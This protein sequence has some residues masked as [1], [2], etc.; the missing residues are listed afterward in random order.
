MPGDPPAL[1]RAVPRTYS[2]VA[3]VAGPAHRARREPRFSF[4]PRRGRDPR[5]AGDIGGSSGM[6]VLNGE[7]GQRSVRS[8][9]RY[10]TMAIAVT[11]LRWS[12]RRRWRDEPGCA[13]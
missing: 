9:G 7:Q 13:A 1:T 10:G 5:A 2:G 11:V 12:R 4:E 8:N 6:L 3:G